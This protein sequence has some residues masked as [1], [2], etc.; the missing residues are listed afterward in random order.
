MSSLITGFNTDMVLEEYEKKK[1]DA[2]ECLGA[3]EQSKNELE[4]SVCFFGSFGDS[5]CIHLAP[6]KDKVLGV[7]CKSAWKLAYDKLNIDHIAPE[8]HKKEFQRMLANPPEF[9]K[10]NIYDIFKDYVTDPIGMAYTAFA[11]IFMG[12]DKFYKSHDNFGVGKKGLPKRVII[13]GCGCFSYDCGWGKVADV[14]NALMRYRGMPNMC[15]SAHEASDVVKY[16]GGYIKQKRELSLK[17][18]DEGKVP[19]AY[20]DDLDKETHVGT[21]YFGLTF[22]QFGNGNVHIIFDKQSMDDINMCLATYYGT[23]LPD[24]WEHT[25]KPSES[26]AVSKDLQF[27]KTPQKACKSFMDHIRLSEGDI[28]LEPSC[29]DGAL[30]DAIV[31]RSNDYRVPLNINLVGVEFDGAR[32]QICRQKGYTVH[33]E[34]FLTFETKTKFDKVVMNPP[35]SGTHY[36]KHIKHALE[37]LKEGGKLYAILPITARDKHGLVD[38]LPYFKNWSNLPSGSFKESGTNINTV[39]LEIRKD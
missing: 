38:E 28:I 1:Q 6:H 9:T 22:K 4:A 33:C 29:G 7:L 32:A 19:Y 34:N 2:I 11:E 3:Y 10:Q 37:L 20:Y 18:T 30:L 35:F 23:V 5:L 14:I 12:L 31:N 17:A 39:V 24:A 25:D 27:Y 36:I 21:G 13:G 8:S 16:G 15:L 26:K